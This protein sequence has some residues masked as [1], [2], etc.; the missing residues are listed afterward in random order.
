MSTKKSHNDVAV[1][2]RDAIIRRGIP[3]S[4][5]SIVPWDQIIFTYS[6]GMAGTNLEK[7]AIENTFLACIRNDER[8]QALLTPQQREKISHEA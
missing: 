1:I 7:S 2:C 4:E 3:V 5:L 6:R 8:Y